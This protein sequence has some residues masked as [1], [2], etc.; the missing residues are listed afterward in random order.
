MR[1]V[2]VAAGDPREH[3]APAR[4]L[5]LAASSSQSSST[6]TTGSSTSCASRRGSTGSVAASTTASMARFAS[7]S[8]TRWTLFLLRLSGSGSELVGGRLVV[9]VVEAGGVER[10]LAGPEAAHEQL[11][12]VRE[13]REVDDALLVELE[14]REEAHDELEP[15]R[16]AR[17]RGRG[18]SSAR[19][20]G[21][22]RSTV[23][24]ASRTL[25]RTGA[26]CSVSTI[27]RRDRGEHAERGRAQRVGADALERV[28]HEQ[29]VRL[30][31]AGA[32]RHAALRHGGCAPRTR[33]PRP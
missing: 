14:H 26:M 4:L 11:A 29:A 23:S 28:G 13:L 2:A 21:S 8:L 31:G 20:A 12:E 1:L 3:E 17:R 10:D 18:S 16:H 32:P 27:D 24:T 15:R 5:V 7:S 25:A 33:R 9:P 22:R 30:F 6:R 19:T